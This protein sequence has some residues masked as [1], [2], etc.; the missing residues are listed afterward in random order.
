MN[1]STSSFSYS[2]SVLPN[3]LRVITVPMQSTRTVTVLVMVGTGSRY[4]SR[5]INGLS[6][7]LEHMMF[8]GTTKRPQAMDIAE[9]LDAIGA[10]YNAFT[11]KEYTGYYIKCSSDRFDTAV[12]VI[13]DIF[14]NSVFKDEEINKERGPI[15]EEINMYRDTPAR[16]VSEL[17]DSLMFGDT[18]LGWDIAGDKETIDKLQR[19]QFVEY[20]N[21]H[22]FAQNTVVV[23]AG[24]VD[25]SS[26]H[27]KVQ[28]YFSDIREHEV[29]QPMSYKSSQTAPAIKIFNKK[30]DQTNIVL[31]FRGLSYLDERIPVVEV[32]S[33]ILGGGMSSRLFSEV[34]EKRGLAYYVGS[35]TGSFRETGQIAASAG[36]NNDNLIPALEIILAQ[37]KR[38]A[39]EAVSEKELRKAKDNIKGTTAIGLESSSSQAS[40]FADQELLEQ[41]IRTIDE[42]LA[43]IEEVTADQIQS[44]SRELFVPDQLNL[45]LIGPFSEDERSITSL[46][47]G[48]K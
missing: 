14:K 47:N 5:E 34:R 24:N 15:K 36:L 3:G 30:T 10:S 7:F 20:F 45:A 33:T 32:I 31:G 4:E 42:Q 29:M 41:R 43:K 1:G 6:H 18:P 37:F 2:R 12:D 40:F 46:I 11:S 39:D 25:A 19:P 48:W 44:L 8:K 21:S 28:E 26:A 23:V 17:F 27:G 35:S 9:E 38:M 13:S 22:Y 16:H